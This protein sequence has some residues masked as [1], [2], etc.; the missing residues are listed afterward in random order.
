LVIC[1]EDEP[2]C[3]GKLIHHRLHDIGTLEVQVE[4]LVRG[5]PEFKDNGGDS[6]TTGGDSETKGRNSETMG[7]NS[8]TMGVNSGPPSLC[9]RTGSAC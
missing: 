6:E 4:R 2:V 1:L 8:E 5:G 3:Y 7:V 9:W